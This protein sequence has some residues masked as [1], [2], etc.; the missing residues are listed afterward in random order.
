VDVGSTETTERIGNTRSVA[1]GL[2]CPSKA[3]AGG[4][5]LSENVTL[6]FGKG[7]LSDRLGLGGRGDDGGLRSL[8]AVSSC[9]VPSA[10]GTSC[11]A[12]LLSAPPSCPGD[13]FLIPSSALPTRQFPRVLVPRPGSIPPPNH[14]SMLRNH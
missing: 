10:L 9:V 11:A 13:M 7:A 14:N 5:M 1:A 8:D 2:S 12:P 3:E 4:R 6:G